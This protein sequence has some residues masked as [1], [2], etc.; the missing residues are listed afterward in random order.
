ML[1]FVR[2]MVKQILYLI[3]RTEN[4]REEKHIY[5]VQTLIMSP[6]YVPVTFNQERG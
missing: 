2:Q 5:V 4:E 6:H 1:S 3:C